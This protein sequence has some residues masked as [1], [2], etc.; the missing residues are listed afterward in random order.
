VTVVGSQWT[1]VSQP[2]GQ[3]TF[4]KVI[5]AAD[6]NFVLFALLFVL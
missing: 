4:Q 1:V 6:T 3:K 5:R 2:E